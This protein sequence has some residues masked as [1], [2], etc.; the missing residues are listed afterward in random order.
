MKWL[1]IAIGVAV[2][3][4]LLYYWRAV[5]F[6]SAVLAYTAWHKIGHWWLQP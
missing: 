4:P 5:I 6:I 2:A 1:K 3:V